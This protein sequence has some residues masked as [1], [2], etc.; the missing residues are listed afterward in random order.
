MQRRKFINYVGLG[1]IASYLP[2]ALAA[3]A[4]DIT[5]EDSTKPELLTVGTTAQ[6]EESG[7]LLDEESNVMVVKDSAGKLIAVNP[8]CTHQGCT[9]EWQQ[10]EN[11][12]LCP[13]HAA[14]YATDGKVLAPPAPEPL[15][16][17]K[18]IA[19]QG[20]IVVET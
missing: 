10:D 3:C 4:N 16:T 13:C 14:K 6:L 15:S 11:V 17:Y 18:A 20:K 19:E 12:F 5:Q 9:V 7:F 1:A 8:T 2:V